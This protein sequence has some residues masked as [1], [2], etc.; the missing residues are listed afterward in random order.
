MQEFII[1]ETEEIQE[2]LHPYGDVTSDLIGERLIFAIE[3]NI[4]LIKKIVGGYAYAKNEDNECD[5]DFVETDSEI[6]FE[7]SAVDIDIAGLE[8]LC[9]YLYNIKLLKLLGKKMKA[10][11]C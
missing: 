4:F 7:A 5:K 11:K 3:D 1:T 8:G 10:K 9:D 2:T 6:I